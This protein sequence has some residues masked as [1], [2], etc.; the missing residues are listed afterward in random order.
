MFS[1]GMLTLPGWA[2]SI[3]PLTISNP[4]LNVTCAQADYNHQPL[5]AVWNQLNNMR[6]REIS[7]TI[8]QDQVIGKLQEKDNPA[9]QKIRDTEIKDGV[10]L[11]TLVDLI[12]EDPEVA[13]NKDLAIPIQTTVGNIIDLI[14]EDRVKEITMIKIAESNT[15]PEYDCDPYNIMGYWFRLGVFALVFAAL[16][17]ITLEFIDRDKR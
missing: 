11:G 5:N 15:K 16:A 14:G 3:T 7:V 9:V 4:A 2:K 12:A 10:S 17:V 13:N 1:G 8:T 6:D